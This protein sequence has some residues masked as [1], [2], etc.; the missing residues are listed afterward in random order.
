MFLVAF[1]CG[2]EE[3]DRDMKI[4]CVAMS[5]S[6]HT[7]R[8]LAQVADLGW[9]I[10]LFPGWDSG[11][12]HPDITNTAVYHTC[13][14]P[15]R[16]VDKSNKQNGVPIPMEHAAFFCRRLIER[17]LPNFR[18]GQLARLISRVKPDLV[19]SMEIQHAGYLTLEAK[20]LYTKNFPP[21]IVTNWGSDIYL[22]GRLAGHKNKIREVL[23]SADFYSCECER[24]VCLA[25]AF[26]FVGESLPVVPNTGGFDLGAIS[27]LR[28]EGATDQRRVIMV[29]GYQ[30]WAGRALVAL[31]ALE[32]C[33][34]LLNG[35]TVAIYSAS[36]DVEMAAELFQDATGVPIVIIPK[37][38]SHYDML[39]WQ[40][41][42]RVSIGL[43]IG[44]AISTSL[45][46]AMVMGSFPVQSWTACADEWIDTGV[47]GLLVPPEDPD[48]VEQAL[49]LALTD[50]RLVNS[51]AAYNSCM[52]RERL[53]GALV[54]QKVYDM[55]QRV[56]ST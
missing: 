10:H 23:A 32:R 19:H 33:A 7:A 49:R 3:S 4:L 22:F 50:D 42:A 2:E 6:I 36:P 21:W 13:Y 8:W 56:A 1:V 26:G 53:D 24:D 12:L 30:T 25:R 54:K 18:A 34:D 20:K 28:Q 9:E 5:E 11:H 55:Y 38:T 43:S 29:K 40:G 27:A 46:E 52:A 37:G 45:L 17:C 51:A 47:N 14:N 41:R 15:F 16:Y 44:D 48:Q 39:T 35:Y 31:R